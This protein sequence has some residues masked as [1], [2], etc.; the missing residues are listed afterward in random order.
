MATFK[1]D[2]VIPLVE[3]HLANLCSSQGYATRD[4]I[5]SSILNDPPSR[6][7]V[8]D[9]KSK[10]TGTWDEVKIAG[11]MVDWFSANYSVGGKL[12]QSARDQFDRTKHNGKWTYYPKGSPPAAISAS[13]KSTSTVKGVGRTIGATAS[14]TV[15]FSLARV[16]I[17]YS[18]D[19]PAH[20]SWVERLANNLVHNGVDVAFDQWELGLG[21]DAAT[22]MERGVRDS[23]WVIVIC[24][25]KYVE[26]ANNGLG[27]AGYE[28]MIMTA[29]LVRSQAKRKFIPVLRTNNFPPVPTFLESKIYVDFTDDGVYA[30]SM[31]E[32]L[33]TI[34]SAP[35]SKK[36]PIG[37][38]PFGPGGSGSP[39]IV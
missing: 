30:E 23:D 9:A 39:T 1:L 12:T 26:K 31:E 8:D 19:S 25:D 2:R 24:T 37:R 17:S 21:S 32:L 38:N 20:K 29:E 35:R 18:H 3:S 33:R 11:N 34:H 36:P 6:K 15:A 7:V 10:S 28:K 16:F 14:P 27:G 13:T 22:F 4:S 5:V